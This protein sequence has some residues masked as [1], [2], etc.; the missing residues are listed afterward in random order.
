MG[1][2]FDVPQGFILG[3]LLFNIFL[4]DL[5][6]EFENNL[7]ANYA[8]DTTPCTVGEN[9]EVITELTNISQQLFTW[10]PNNQMKANHGKSHLVLSS[11]E[12]LSIQIGGVVINSPQSEKLLG[13]HFDNKLKFD[14]HI[15]KTGRKLIGN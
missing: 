8:D 1:I 2:L 12:P 3:P 13:V 6:L 7:F 15:N 5:L 9:T 14:I 11:P 4:C 10:F